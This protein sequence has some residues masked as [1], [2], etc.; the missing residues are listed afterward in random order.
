MAVGDGSNIIIKK[1][2][3]G[4]DW[5]NINTQQAITGIAPLFFYYY[6]GTL[7]LYYYRLYGSSGDYVYFVSYD[8]ETGVFGGATRVSAI[9]DNANNIYQSS[10]IYYNGKY[11]F[12]D[13]R[14]RRYEGTP[15]NGWTYKEDKIYRSPNP[16]IVGGLL[17][18]FYCGTDGVY[19]RCYDGVSWYDSVKISNLIPSYVTAIKNPINIAPS[20]SPYISSLL[21]TA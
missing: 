17:Y 6:G 8:S 21:Y 13:G 18:V 9:E 20:I 2:T 4:Y 11:N 15:P 12:F 14:G 5:V 10:I 7:Y 16:V 3:N 1:S 19:Y